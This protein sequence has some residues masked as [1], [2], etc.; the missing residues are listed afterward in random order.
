MGSAG[1]GVPDVAGNADPQTGY[2]V[3]V[4]GQ[5][6]VIGGTSAVAPLWAA[7]IAR[8]NQKLG[9]PLGDAHAALYRLGARAFNDITSGNNGA[10]QAGAGWDAC[11]G[12]G[13]PAGRGTARG[14]RGAEGLSAGRQRRVPRHQERRAA[15]EAGTGCRGRSGE[16]ERAAAAA[17]PATGGHT[18]STWVASV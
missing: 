14:A 6:Q 12:L 9:R 16:V 3:L 8:C 13:S 2:Q 11:T 1:R 7:L 18:V 15:G 4:D 17:A 10:Y 5:A